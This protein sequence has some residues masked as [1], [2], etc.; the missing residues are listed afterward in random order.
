LYAELIDESVNVQ[1][2]VEEVGLD[3]PSR[4]ADPTSE[5][6]PEGSLGVTATATVTA[7]GAEDGA[8][9]VGAFPTRYSTFSCFESDLKITG[10]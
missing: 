1:S 10:V 2:V 8:E 3:V 4:R 7:G 9:V 5:K 6:L